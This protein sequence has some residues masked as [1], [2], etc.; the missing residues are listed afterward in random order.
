[1]SLD[2]AFAFKADAADDAAMLMLPIKYRA[3]NYTFFE[4]NLSEISWW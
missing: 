4:Y 3:P 2:R 1:M